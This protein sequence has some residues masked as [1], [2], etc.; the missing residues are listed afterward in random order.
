MTEKASVREIVEELRHML[1]HHPS[2]DL[3]LYTEEE[4][5]LCFAGLIRKLES[6]LFELDSEAETPRSTLAYWKARTRR[7][8]S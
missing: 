7:Q 4:I 3:E 1:L 5:G 6:L 2:D 8:T